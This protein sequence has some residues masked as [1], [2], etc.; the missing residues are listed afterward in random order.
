VLVYGPRSATCGRPLVLLCALQELAHL[1]H[2]YLHGEQGNRAGAGG[3]A[4][5]QGCLPNGEPLPNIVL[6]YQVQRP[7]AVTR[8]CSTWFHKWLLARL[9][10]LK[11]T[12][13]ALQQHPT[14]AHTTNFS[15]LLRPG[16]LA[17]GVG[18]AA[19]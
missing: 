10:Q 14:H 6:R 15:L 2:Y 4:A 16:G 8:S 9:V 17:P 18:A 11:Q 19:G 3:S 13:L 1:Y 5:C 7:A 12:P